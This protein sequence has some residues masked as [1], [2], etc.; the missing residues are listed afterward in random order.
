M[1]DNQMKIKHLIL[2]ILSLILVVPTVY[3]DDYQDG[4]AA[5]VKKDFKAALKKLKPLA[6]KGHAKTQNKLGEMYGKGQVVSQDYK[7]AFKWYQLAGEQG[8]AIAQYNLGMMYANGDGVP[9]DYKETV[10]WFQLAAEQGYAQDQFNMGAWYEYGIGVDQDLLLAHMWYNLA[11]SNGHKDG[12]KY[13]NI[14]EKKMTPQQI[15]KAQE[16]ARNWKP[17]N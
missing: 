9:Q 14:L 12:P 11:G 8:N 5:F 1:E 2:I 10:K 6:E 7:E 3:A 13:K 15:E 16:M 17:R 4:L